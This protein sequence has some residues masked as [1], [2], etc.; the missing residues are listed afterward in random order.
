MMSTPVRLATAASVFALVAAPAGA[1]DLYRP[2]SWSAMVT[3]RSAGRVGDSLTVVIYETSS[4]KNSAQAGSQRNSQL[5]LQTQWGSSSSQSGLLGMNSKFAN[6]AQTTRSGTLTAQI[7]VVVDSVLANGD[8]HVS[9][10]QTVEISGERT[11][12]HV[13]GRVRPEDI[14]PDDSIV[15]TR[16]ADATIQYNGKGLLSSDVKRGFINR[17]TDWIG[18]P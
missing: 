4:A 15:S 2:G 3:D 12:I 1:T 18:L 10:D 6:N 9:G 8:L 16:L 7:S 13:A 5:G 17:I 14:A 11:H